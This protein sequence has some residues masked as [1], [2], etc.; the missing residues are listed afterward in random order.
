MKS[1]NQQCQL[2]PGIS[3]YN[4]YRVALQYWPFLTQCALVVLLSVSPATWAACP[5]AGSGI[6][7][8]SGVAVNETGC[9]ISTT[10][11]GVNVGA[12]GNATLSNSTITIPSGAGVGVASQGA[13]AKLTLNDVVIRDETGTGVLVNNTGNLTANNL[14][15]VTNNSQQSLVPLFLAL[16]SYPNLG[17]VDPI[18]LDH[19][20]DPF[21]LA[22]YQIAS[23]AIG[24]SL[25]NST[26]T[27]TGNTTITSGG[28]GIL[29]T[30]SNVTINGQLLINAG[31]GG[32]T[33]TW[34][35]GLKTTGGALTVTTPVGSTSTINVD[36]V[37][38]SGVFANAISTITLNG[39]G[40]YKINLL[41]SQNAGINNVNEAS[42]L[43]ADASTISVVGN[44]QLSANQGRGYGLWTGITP[45]ST[46]NI[47]GDTT[48]ATHG[49]EAFGIRLDNGAMS[50][51][52]KLAIVTGVDPSSIDA[53][54]G[55]AS[56]G[57]RATQGTLTVSGP[58]TVT[59]VGGIAAVG[60][61]AQT[62][63]SAYGL[64]NTSYSRLQGDGA[65][66]NFSGPTSIETSGIAAHG[67]YNDSRTG[68]FTFGDS[69]N[70]VTHG[71]QGS[72][73]WFR[74][75][76]GILSSIVNETVGAWGVN[77]AITGTTTFRGPLSITTDQDGAGGVRATGGLVD[78][79]GAL[80][81]I[82]AG[83]GAYGIQ[84]SSATA[85]GTTYNGTV[86]VG[87]LATIQTSGAAA[88]DVFA[89]QNGSIN[90]NG[91][92]RLR[93]ADPAAK[94]ILASG[95]SRVNGS[96]TFDV[97]ANLQ[98]QNT[99][100]LNLSMAPGS[101][102]TG[103]TTRT[104]T[105]VFNL[106]LQNARWNLTGDSN[107]STLVNDPSLIDFAPPSGGVF[108]TLTVNNYS[109]DG[110]LALN[111]FLGDDS[112]PSDK[113]VI[114][115]GTATGNSALSIKN[116]L[117]QG[118]LTNGNGILVVD[119][120]NGGT[121]AANAFALAGPVY[122]GPYEYTLHRS[123]TDDTNE[124]AYY[125]RSDLQPDPPT[126]VD[127]ASH[128]P[129]F[130]PQ[131]SLYGAI[132]ALAL[133]YSRNIID[134]LHE[135]VGEERLNKDE[136]L[137]T[138][139]EKTYGPS[140]GWGRVIYRSGEQDGDHNAFGRQ[141]PEYNYDMTAFQVGS[142]L[143]RNVESDGSH[144]Q[145]GVSLAIGTIDGGVK[146]SNVNAGDD[147]L[148]AYSLGGYWTHFEPS[149]WYFDGVIQVNRFD[150]EAKPNGLNKLETR[151][152]GYTASVESGYPIQADKDFYIEP[153]AQL[154]YSQFD[155][156]DS[157]DLAADVRFRDIDSLIGRLGVRFAKDWD[158]EGSDNT[159]RRTN[160]WIRPSVWHEFKGQP[161]T[162]FSSQ[163][164]FVPFEADLDGTWGEVN[165]G[166]DY[167]ANARTTFTVSAGYRQAFDNDSRGYDGM[168]GFKIKF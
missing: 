136:L 162:E 37:A 91:G 3:Q 49:R 36:S 67:V 10:S 14:T 148:R 137:P 72:V 12:N 126:P 131:T 80:N 97:V 2:L 53:L 73:T 30:N 23:P 83:A 7:A 167:Q 64:W 50:L 104:D 116:T 110:T 21:D 76:N 39:T 108:K 44:L 81:V 51:R 57:L 106:T 8:G 159:I 22:V 82:T 79:Q 70:I 11:T 164:G 96:G 153:Q 27:L 25:N 26:A 89:D 75:F 78:A 105:S 129:N 71:G 93:V 147:T 102:F 61:S 113:L 156:D 40:L 84:A 143:Y 1:S 107:L 123:S 119:A 85:G 168:V 132:P 47:V 56:P 24:V 124:Q 144:D 109:G 6:T 32:T 157:D 19:T 29:S 95:N 166:V 118:A 165:M 125:L 150:I 152:W 133:V 139:D 161:K 160:G 128:I 154:V 90:L 98:S 115:G 55:A 18:D 69:V 13:N 112:S 120:V 4:P 31:P 35:D 20:N 68:T 63:E 145:A 16:P 117:G 60:S 52:G 77:N 46:I 66:L 138:D 121:T 45:T 38:G 149:G 134:T 15:V 59:T 103:T 155:L 88:H 86:N 43:R 127:P 100:Q 146:H 28:A 151:G 94:G 54:A 5:A 142:D 122:A 130:R 135:R 163:N 42:G 58:T 101:V 141:T 33:N 92:A 140:M 74:T 99:A 111:T 158:T 62:R 48:I 17:G 65:T 114:N 41:N 34:M 9:A 87:G